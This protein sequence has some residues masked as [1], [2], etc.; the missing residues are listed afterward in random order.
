MNN[1]KKL[2]KDDLVALY[3]SVS[4]KLS[5]RNGMVADYNPVLTLLMGCNTN[6]LF[7]GSREQGK[8]ALFYI[9][10]YI[11]KNLVYIIDSFDLIIEAQEHASKYPSIADDSGIQNVMCS[12][13]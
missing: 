11:C 6:S 2:S 1:L 9:G 8:G 12:M 4:E 13:S 7:S 10:P 5:S 3:Q